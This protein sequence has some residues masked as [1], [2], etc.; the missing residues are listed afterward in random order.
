MNIVVARDR[1]FLQWRFGADYQLFLARDSQGPLGYAAVR[2]ITRAGLRVGMVVD[3]LTVSDGINALPL[4]EAVIRWLREQGASAA[5]GYFRRGSAAWRQ[6]R[7]GGFLRLPRPL[8]PRDYPV[9]AS[10][11][12]EEPYQAELLDASRWH[13]SLT[14]SDLA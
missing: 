6:A 14:D 13:M 5:M 9:C 2:L 11:R 3:F 12:P 10:V 1:A 8:V 4:F 7:A